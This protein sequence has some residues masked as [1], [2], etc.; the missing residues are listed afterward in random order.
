MAAC[1]GSQRYVSASNTWDD[2]AGVGGNNGRKD[3][4]LLFDYVSTRFSTNR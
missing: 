4:L 1:A 2:G 3:E